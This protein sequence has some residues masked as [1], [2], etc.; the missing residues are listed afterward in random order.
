MS[1]AATVPPRISWTRAVGDRGPTVD[2]VALPIRIA[3]KV[4]RDAITELTALLPTGDTKQDKDIADALERLDESL[5][6]KLWIDDATLG[7]QGH[8][9]FADDRFAIHKL[10]GAGADA[11]ALAK[12]LAAI[13]EELA[14]AAVDA[15][16][17][18]PA[19]ARR[20]A[21]AQAALAAGRA[22]AAAGDLEGAVDLYRK[23]WEDARRALGV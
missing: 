23:A 8:K 20:L 16:L 1:R 7:D 18:G 6:S 21:A 4:K 9:V 5:A 2:G 13:D 12:S 15:A 14:A 11:A 19:D 17:G 10:L 22:A 3:S